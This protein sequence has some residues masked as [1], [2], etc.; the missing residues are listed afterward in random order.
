MTKKNQQQSYEIL[1]KKILNCHKCEGLN[2]KGSTESAPG[3]GNIYSKIMIIGQ[4]LCRPCMETKIPFTGGSGRLLDRAFEEAGM[5]KSEAFITNVVH[6]HPPDNRKSFPHEIENCKNYLKEELE[7]L[8]PK[9]IIPLGMDAVISILGEELWSSSVG[10][11][12]S[13]TKHTVFP[14]YHPSYIMKQGKSVINLY[15]QNLARLL[16]ANK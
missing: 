7:I 8:D 14:Q 13:L 11:K 12:I 15:V 6:C 1:S 16:R 5:K 4:S 9:T 2:E 10:K 3:Y